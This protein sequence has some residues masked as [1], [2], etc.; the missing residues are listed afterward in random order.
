MSKK[1]FISC[2]TLLTFSE[3]GLKPMFHNRAFNFC[4]LLIALIAFLFLLPAQRVLAADI[5]VGGNCNLADAIRAANTNKKAGGCPRGRGAD[6]IILT[7]SITLSSPLP[8]IK[9]N[10]TIR[11]QGFTISGANKYGVFFIRDAREFRVQ[12]LTLSH[13]LY[14][15]RRHARY[16]GGAIACRSFIRPTIVVRNSVFSHNGALDYGTA[17]DCGYASVDVRGSLFENNSGYFAGAIHAENLDIRNSTFRNNRA[18]R[19]GG[20]ISGQ[21]VEIRNSTFRGNET[22]YS[23]SEPGYEDGYGGGAI[24]V[25][26]GGVLT[27]RKSVFEHNR[28]AGKGATIYSFGGNITII[29]SKLGAAGA[30]GI[31]NVGGTVTIK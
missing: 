1:T 11:G 16:S 24:F 31:V 9:S 14:G 5:T 15:Y 18:V 21:N 20:A 2:S 28:T 23:E 6:T 13:A 27:V 17:I 25:G 22:W 19:I 8:V 4:F 26:R 7:G 29:N 12:N 3:E 30:A 10:I